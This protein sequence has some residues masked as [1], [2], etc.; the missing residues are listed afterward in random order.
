MC[1][2]EHFRWKTF[3]LACGFSDLLQFLYL[4]IRHKCVLSHPL[5]IT[6]HKIPTVVGSGEGEGGGR[7]SFILM[8]PSPAR[9]TYNWW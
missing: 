5:Q 9:F 4:V 7:E 8:T 1:D 6:T 2:I 3:Y